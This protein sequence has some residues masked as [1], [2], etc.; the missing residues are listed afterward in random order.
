MRHCYARRGEKIGDAVSFNPRFAFVNAPSTTSSSAPPAGP[1]PTGDAEQS[2]ESD[3]EHRTGTVVSSTGSWYEVQTAGGLVSSK[4]SGKLRL[5]DEDVTNPLAVGDRVTLRISPEDGTGYITAIH[6]RE[7]ALTR[8]AAG[9]RAG[10]RHVIVANVDAAWAVQAVRRPRLNPGFLDR[11]LVMAA[12]CD[13]PAGIIFNKTDL[14]RPEDEERVASL[15]ALYEDLGYLVLMTSATEGEGVAAVKDALEGR[16]SVLSGPS[17][18]GK[19]TLLNAIEPGLG[20]R[21]GAVSDKTNKGRHTTTHAALYP[22]TDLAD[23]SFVADTPGIR[24]FGILDL[25]PDELCHFFVEFFDYLDG[26]KFIDCTHD[27][28]P[29]C[30]IKEAVEAGEI[31]ER[32]YESYLNILQSLREGEARRDW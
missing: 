27:H 32:R 26:C 8:R 21:T 3:E 25:E 10:Q 18:A 13:I 1:V 14:T 7:N 20:L 19:S 9:R 17:G 12:V 28:E 23:G 22:L 30:A 11:F 4:A 2:T 15:R 31:D 24:E 6:E 29:G 16:L 5:R